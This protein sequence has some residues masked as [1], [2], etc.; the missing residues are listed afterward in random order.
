MAHNFFKNQEKNQLLEKL[1]NS[2]K[3]LTEKSKIDF[4]NLKTNPLSN[5]YN[6][7]ENSQEKII[8]ILEKFE[9]SYPNLKIENLDTVNS[10]ILLYNQCINEGITFE[11]NDTLQKY[12]YLKNFLTSLI[13]VQNQKI[14]QQIMSNIKN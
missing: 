10:Y 11:E 8:K 14:N 4:S 3:I 7:N 5:S 6:F 12:V 9:E 2:Y 13:S 1:R